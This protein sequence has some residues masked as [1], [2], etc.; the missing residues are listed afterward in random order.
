MEEVLQLAGDVQVRE[1]LALGGADVAL[2]VGFASGQVGCDGVD[3][4]AATPDGG[5]H[6]LTG[7]RAD[8]S[9]RVSNQATSGNFA[10]GE[11]TDQKR[12]EDDLLLKAW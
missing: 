5:T 4:G 3:D 2:E 10:G 1:E 6:P 7:E 8:R 11:W 9:C 12:R